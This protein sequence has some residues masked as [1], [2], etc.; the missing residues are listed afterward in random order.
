MEQPEQP[1]RRRRRTHSPEFKAELIASRQQ[2]G[3][4]VTAIAMDHGINPNLLRRWMIEH[5][6]LGRHE[7]AETSLTQCDVAAQFIPLRLP[8]SEATPVAAPQQQEILIDLQRGNLS[9]SIRWPMAQSDRCAA[10][11]REVMR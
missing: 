2:P 10:W 5:E 6:R 4:S 7:L 8:K 1:T 11:L 3:V 9:A